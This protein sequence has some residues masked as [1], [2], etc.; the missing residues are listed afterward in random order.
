MR[1]NRHIG[2]GKGFVISIACL[3]SILAL[4]AFLR[5]HNLGGRPLYGDEPWN[6]VHI[7]AQPVSFIMQELYGSILYTLILH[8]L[9]P[10]GDTVVMARLPA[11]VFGLL[12]VFGV[13]LAA[14]RL[15]GRMDAL[16][17]ALL[18]A[19][20]THSIFF[21][22]QA[23]GYSG[24]LFFSV[25][26]LYFFLKALEDNKPGFWVLYA[27][28]SMMGAYMHFFS[29]ILIP[30]HGLYLAFLWLERILSR[31]GSG[32]ARK[33]FARIAAFSLSVLAVLT[34]TY[35][36]HA[37]IEKP[38]DYFSRTSQGVFQVR[39]TVDPV[40]VAWDTLKRILVHQKSPVLFY[41]K[42]ALCLGGAIFCLKNKR[43]E[44][45]LLLIYCV[46]PFILFSLSNPYLFFLPADNKFIFLAPILCILMARGFVQGARFVAAGLFRAGVM[47]NQ[48]GLKV[49]AVAVAVFLALLLEGVFVMDYRFHFWQLQSTGKR[50]DIVRHLKPRLQ[51]KE[52]AVF[53]DS[54]DKSRLASVAPLVYPDGRVRGVVLAEDESW[55]KEDLFREKGLWVFFK[56][57][58]DGMDA[59]RR[60]SGYSSETRVEELSKTLAV[61][62]AAEDG[63]L[64][65]KLLHTVDVLAAAA[66]GEERRIFELLNAKMQLA[67]EGRAETI[68]A[69][70][71]DTERKPG[72]RRSP[73]R[74]DR[75]PRRIRNAVL[76]SGYQ[77]P[78]KAVENRL[79]SDISEIVLQQ[80][81][82]MDSR[83]RPEDALDLLE[84]GL[85]LDPGNIGLLITA[86]GIHARAGRLNNALVYSVRILETAPGPEIQR[87]I[88]R[89]LRGLPD[90]NPAFL[91]WRSGH[92]WHIRWWTDRPR[93][94]SGRIQSTLPIIRIRESGPGDV[95]WNMSGDGLAFESHARRDRFDGLDFSAGH[96]VELTVHVRIEG[97]RD[98]AERA[99]LGEKE[100]ARPSDIPFI[101]SRPGRTGPD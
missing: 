76:Y 91:I 58:P 15:L 8:V 62:F 64:L 44:L 87:D 93:R 90:M 54:L 77:S 56:K 73:D 23:R 71:S 12:S 67:A 17:A 96:D 37:H 40:A 2:Q 85:A 55:M 49:R 14:R 46:P 51:E 99:I 35:I 4:A 10:L 22:Q 98:I 53:A 101:L 66:G 27:A 50:G 19:L 28:S 13:F 31:G 5:F 83:N 29:L 6:T 79:I 68:R 100:R 81:G 1:I 95:R 45:A 16:F 63:I 9:L 48:A 42:L 74:A 70:I 43:R 88:M 92:T 21:S 25:F 38:M 94:F 33:I 24:L 86:A 60:L 65:N 52:Y 41:L 75:L 72:D 18:L 61:R 84:K 69:I 32:G 59:A 39:M 11:A 97:L 36:L 30:L 80:S 82:E 26:T 20:S 47:R 89:F 3:V 7:A 34:V 78:F 57:N